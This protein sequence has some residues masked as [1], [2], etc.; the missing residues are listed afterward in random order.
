M[1]LFPNH[2]VR[3]P[4]PP[5]FFGYRIFHEI[6]PPAMGDP[7]LESPQMLPNNRWVRGPFARGFAWKWCN[8]TREVVRF[9][10]Q[11]DVKV[12]GHLLQ[13][14]HRI[15]ALS[16]DW[17]K[18]KFTG[19]PQNSWENPWFPVSFPSNPYI[20]SGDFLHFA[21]ENK[22]FRTIYRWFIAPKKWVLIQFACGMTGGHRPE[23]GASLKADG[24]ATEPLGKNAV[25][26]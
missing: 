18:G 12:L 6:N 10:R 21:M 5:N 8:A 13:K 20:D 23:E 14:I 25:C 9:N 16:M 4:N 24:W 17:L 11:R 15:A 1:P 22:W 7:F 3:P 26:A 2:H 19:K